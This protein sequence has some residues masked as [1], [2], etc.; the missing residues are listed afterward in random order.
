MSAMG[1]VRALLDPEAVSVAR[2]PTV[3]LRGHRPG[4]MGWVVQRHG[5]LY[6]NE[7]G[8]DERFEALV[9]KIVSRF[10]ENLDPQRERCW[11]AE[12]DGVKVG[13]IFLVRHA[14][15]E[16]VAQLRLFLVQPSARG[17]GIGHRLVGDCLRFARESGYRAVTLWTNDVLS[18]A[19]H[20]YIKAGFELVLEE[21][22]HS[23]GHD[24]TAQTWELAL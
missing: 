3:I 15:R 18:A 23:Y 16:G 21:Q 9:A 5:E 19:R 20:I 22:H 4:D 17:L 1:R 11:I 7:Y 12:L 2:E 24:L 13:C 8:F 6:F 10:I 14:E